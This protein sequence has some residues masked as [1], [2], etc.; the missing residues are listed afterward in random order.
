MNNQHD[1]SQ[2]DQRNFGEKNN[3][4]QNQKQPGQ[5]DQGQQRKKAP[6][7]ENDEEE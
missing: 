1:Q 5:G 4:G 3:P 7:Q 6:G 2:N